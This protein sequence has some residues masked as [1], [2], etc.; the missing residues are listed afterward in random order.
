MAELFGNPLTDPRVPDVLVEPQPGVVYSLSKKKVA[1][2][3]G[4]ASDDR[5]VAL[6][7][8]RPGGEDGRSTSEPVSTTSVAPTILRFL[9]LQSGALQAVQA[10]GTRPLPSER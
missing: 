2:H 1:E 5:H 9:G 8:V 6:L 4:A 10:E 7:V 3:G